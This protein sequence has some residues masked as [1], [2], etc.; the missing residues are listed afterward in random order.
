MDDALFEET[1]NEALK[2]PEIESALGRLAADNS[3]T[4]WQIRQQ[5]VDFVRTQRDAL[6]QI[7]SMDVRQYEEARREVLTAGGLSPEPS[8][9]LLSLRS[10]A[11]EAD[12]A[13]AA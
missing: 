13:L 5:I 4:S 6:E 10:A 12:R 9:L 2:Q 7:A 3:S 11:D 1:L 8:P